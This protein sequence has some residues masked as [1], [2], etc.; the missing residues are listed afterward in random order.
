MYMFLQDA[1]ALDVL[2]SALYVEIITVL[3]K[4]SDPS[5]DFV[6]EL[7]KEYLYESS[8]ML[9]KESAL[10][11]ERCWSGEASRIIMYN[12]VA[13]NFLNFFVFL[14][15]SAFLFASRLCSLVKQLY[16]VWD[17]S[18][19]AMIRYLSKYC[20]YF[21]HRPRKLI[22]SGFLNNQTVA[23]RTIGRRPIL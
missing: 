12:Y 21:N 2:K 22:F 4:I 9:K 11:C 17:R 5:C 18:H 19:A 23:R 20:S 6:G 14:S 3:G 16:R 8:L 1:C 7:S 15:I 13:K 10:N